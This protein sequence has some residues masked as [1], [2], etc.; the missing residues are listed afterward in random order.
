M[1]LR[2]YGNILYATG[3]W[4]VEGN[5]DPAAVTEFTPDHIEQWMDDC[6][7]HGVTTV[8]WQANCGG[9]CTHPSPVFPLPGPPLLPHN[10]AWEPVWEFLGRQ[11]RHFDSLSVA[12]RAAHDRGLRFAYALCLDDFVDSPFDRGVFHPDLWMQSRDGESFIG[13]PCCAEPRVQDVLLEHV[14]D[15]LDRGI[16]D[17]VISPF[18]HTQGLGADVPD[19]YGFNPPLARAY[20]DRH[21]ADPRRE[22]FDPAAL[23]VIRGDFHTAL[24]TRLHTETSRRNQ[25]L[26]PWTTHDSQFGRGGSAGNALFSHLNSGTPP[27]ETAPA[28]GIAFQPQRWAELGIADALLVLAPPPDAISAARRV[29]QQ[30]DLPVLL[31]RK[32]GPEDSADAWTQYEDESAQV[33]TGALDGFVAH[34]MISVNYGDYPQRVFDLL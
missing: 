12:I 26:I 25:R 9:T 27:P 32:I 5:G 14:R 3:A 19:H 2:V 7:R 17:L 10:E 22:L 16:D 28:C 1:T 18:A 30:T 23:H 8:L 15:V 29:R 21:G 11:V 31:W 24:L 20:Q 4:A 33:R 34:A 6:A 13:V